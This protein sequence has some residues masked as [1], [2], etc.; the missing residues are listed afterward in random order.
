MGSMK[1]PAATWDPESIAALEVASCDLYFSPRYLDALPWN[2]GIEEA[3]D[4][5]MEAARRVPTAAAVHDASDW[6]VED[7][8]RFYDDV[9]RDTASGTHS[10]GQRWRY[11]FRTVLGTNNYPGIYAGLDV[12]VLL[13]RF[14]EPQ[15]PLVA[16]HAKWGRREGQRSVI[17]VLRSL[18]P[19]EQERLFG[20]VVELEAVR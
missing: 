15:V 2:A 9:L 5:V 17:E 4:L 7:R 6:T 16:P 12:P 13:V 11:G 19:S 1:T 20:R 8:R 10:S 14:T 18:A 3:R